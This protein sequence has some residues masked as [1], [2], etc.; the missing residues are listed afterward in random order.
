MS[1]GERAKM[2]YLEGYNCVE[3]LL[4]ALKEA[5][6]LEVPDQLIEAGSVFWRG[7][8][9][10]GCI[11]GAIIGGALAIGLRYGKGREADGRCQA[12]YRQFLRLFGAPCCRII[13]GRWSSDF[14]CEERR[15]FC[16]N[17]VKEVTEYVRALL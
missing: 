14:H 9:G 17:I 4:M 2:L 3:S 1:V 16:S 11:C 10:R 15:E 7:V 12:L 13:T 6:I 5:E 8:T